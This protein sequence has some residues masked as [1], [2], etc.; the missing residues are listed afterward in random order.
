M[1]CDIEVAIILI[2]FVDSCES[3]AVCRASRKMDS[4]V[5]RSLILDSV[6]LTILLLGLVGWLLGYI[7]YQRFFHPLAKYPGP[8]LASLTD[9]WQTQQFWTLKQPYHLT[10]LHE[11]YGPFVR[12][13][14]DKLSI[15]TEDAVPVIYQKGGRSMPKTEFYDAYGSSHPNI[16][17]MRDEAVRMASV[18]NKM[19]SHKR[20]PEVTLTRHSKAHSIRRRHM[21]HSFSIS[22]VKEMETFLDQ[23]IQILTSKIAGLCDRNEAFDLK[24]FLHYYT[25][26]V[27][28]ELAFSQSFGVQKTDDE[29]LVP[30]VKEHSLLGA[31]TGAW[32]AMTMRLKRWLPLVPHAG[33]R[34]LFQG[35]ASCAKLASQC[36]QRRLSALNATSEKDA[37]A[38]TRQ[39]KDLLTNLILAKHPDTGERLTQTDLETEAFGFM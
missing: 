26:D 2:S 38:T 10:V 32:P 30:P 34:K 27:L 13:G 25:I 1:G 22:Y 29:S 21:S 11:K 4:P 9:L 39:R 23:N 6:L 24:K 17:G 36:V 19:C 28:G 33:L 3:Q 31:V 16:F 15:T 18:G 7:V 20:D 12:Y 37:D 35:R 5:P 14:P 8:F